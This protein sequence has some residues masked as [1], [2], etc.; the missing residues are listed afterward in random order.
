VDNCVLSTVKVIETTDD[1]D[2]DS[3]QILEMLS[4]KSF[5]RNNEVARLVLNLQSSPYKPI[6]TL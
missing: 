1:D 3:D 5:L 2:D 4:Y 6:K